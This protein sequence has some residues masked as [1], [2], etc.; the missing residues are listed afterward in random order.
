MFHFHCCLARDSIRD[1][2]IRSVEIWSSSRTLQQMLNEIN[3]VTTQ[4]EL[5]VKRTDGPERIQKAYRKA[6]LKCHPDK[7]VEFQANCRATEMFKWVN[8]HYSS[9][10]KRHGL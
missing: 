9:Y 10:K 2:I 8:E 1:G 4:D 5:Y 7:H 3:A 6:M